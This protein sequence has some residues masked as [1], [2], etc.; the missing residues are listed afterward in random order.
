MIANA[1]IVE[2][3]FKETKERL[4]EALTNPEQMQSWYFNISDFQPKLGYIF[5]FEGGEPQKRYLHLCKILEVKPTQKLSYSWKYKDY[6]GE[7]FVSFELLSINQGTKLTL[8]HKGLETFTNPDFEQEKFK[9]GW[10]FLLKE[11]LKGY[12]EEGKALRTW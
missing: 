12:L 10:N 7:S 2:V 1:L 9:E 8:K 5:S 6:E 3:K 4:W 11:S